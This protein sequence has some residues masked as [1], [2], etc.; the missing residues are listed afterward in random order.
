MFF[1]NYE[2]TIDEKNRLVI[3]S[4]LREEAGVKV[5]ILKGFD[6]ALSVYKALDFQKLVAE[7]QSLPFNEKI[8]R[9]YIRIQLASAAEMDV[10]KQG[11]IQIPTHLMNKYQMNK[12]VVIIGVGDHFEIWNKDKYLDY[13]KQI[14][15]EFES[16]AEKLSKHE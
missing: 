10:D 9:D 12:E 5:F 3:P 14:E 11:R 8:S 6:G 15:K 4:K 1:G 2:H 7:I 16:N 13:E